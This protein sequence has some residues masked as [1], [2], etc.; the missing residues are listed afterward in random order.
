MG[1]HIGLNP[2]CFP[3][4]STIRSRASS[5]N[6]HFIEILVLMV[7]Y[8]PPMGIVGNSNIYKSVSFGKFILISIS[9][10]HI[11]KQLYLIK[12]ILVALVYGE[13]LRLLNY[14]EEWLETAVVFDNRILSTTVCRWHY[15]IVLQMP[16]QG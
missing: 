10:C 2:I 6:Y 11:K 7:F 15:N 1:S 4:R 8:F 5:D 3:F 13:E 12:H 14:Q 9:L 16:N